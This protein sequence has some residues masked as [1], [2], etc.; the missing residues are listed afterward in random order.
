[1]ASFNPQDFGFDGAAAAPD[2]ATG[3]ARFLVVLFVLCSRPWSSMACP[4]WRNA[5]GTH[6]KPAGHG[7]PSKAGQAREGRERR[8]ASALFRLAVTA[9]SPAVVNVQAHAPNDADGLPACRWGAIPWGRVSR[10]ASLVRE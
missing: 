3:T 4:M 5:R 10:A 2:D 6:G 8:Q 1:M 9:V 7:P